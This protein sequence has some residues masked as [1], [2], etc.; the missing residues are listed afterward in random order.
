[1]IAVFNHKGGVGKT[2]NSI[3][4]AYTIARQHNVLLVEADQQCNIQQHFEKTI[5]E[6]NEVD[7]ISSDDGETEDEEDDVGQSFNPFD[8][9]AS[10]PATPPPTARDYPFLTTTPLHKPHPKHHQYTNTNVYTH[11]K[12]LYQALHDRY[13]FH[14]GLEKSLPH[15]ILL[16]PPTPDKPLEP[17][18]NV[19]LVPGTAE[20][21]ELEKLAS[22]IGEEDKGVSQKRLAMF[23]SMIHDLMLKHDCTYTIIDL[24]P[25]SGF[26]NRILITSCDYIIP[27][28]F[29]DR[30]S[31]GSS[32][33]LLD[34]VLPDWYTWYRHLTRDGMR[35]KTVKRNLPYILPFIVTN[36]GVHCGRVVK[37]AATWLT[38]LNNFRSS[39][40]FVE[41][42][43]ISA[44]G[45]FALPICQSENTMLVDANLSSCALVDL[46]KTSSRNAL[47]NLLLIRNRYSI[48]AH[49]IYTVVNDP[50]KLSSRGQ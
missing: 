19:W 28:C 14:D 16:P 26:I 12:T 25:S 1:M 5:R 41:K 36:Y 40:P 37:K 4:L 17:V 13:T 7:I 33:S 46:K 43:R 49:F 21:M 30:S 29:A 27:P 38:A 39:D 24:S 45:L 23:R 6:S 22:K 50:P 42:H 9:R 2:S 31:Y 34:R 8:T 47:T 10:T 32:V 20:M 35:H 18:K 44:N 15:C 48:L 11:H 3:N